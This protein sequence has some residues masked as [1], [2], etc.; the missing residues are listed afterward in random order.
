MKKQNYNFI[1]LTGQ[2]FGQLKVIKQAGRNKRG[3]ILWECLCKC[4][5]KTMSITSKL[6]GKRKFSCGCQ[7]QAADLLGKT[8]G[9]LKVV[10]IHCRGGGGIKWNC[11]CICG[12]STITSSH[13][14]TA[15]HTQSCGCLH[16]EI[17][18]EIKRSN[19]DGK[20][21]G[22]LIVIKY[23]HTKKKKVWWQCK[24]DCG[25]E[26]IVPTERLATKQTRSCGCLL[27]ETCQ[28]KANKYKQSFIGQKFGL[29][30]VVDV[31]SKRASLKCQCECGS[32]IETATSHLTSGHS[33]SC[34][35]IESHG[36]R[37]ISQYLSKHNFKFEKEFK[38]EKCRRKRKLPFDFCV[39]IKGSINLI[40]FQGLQHY[41]SRELFG[42]IKQL[43][44]QQKNDLIKKKYCKKNKIPL[45][46]VPYWEIENLEEILDRYL[47]EKS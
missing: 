3:I 47:K 18:S 21:F 28:L 27:K 39:W 25:G 13:H 16:K 33:K 20:R 42:G 7:N 6:R 26:I 17:I 15:G 1:D 31:S 10:G 23:S 41:Q 9:R 22:K 46:I 14:L 19:L 29:L 44:E 2:T 11:E 35:C 12:G 5:K 34:G 37:I 24:C 8:F 4:G 30:K 36:E 43:K 32:I 45:L 38:F 40:E